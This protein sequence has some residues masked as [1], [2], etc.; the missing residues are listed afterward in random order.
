MD[1]A[2]QDVVMSNFVEYFACSGE[3]EETVGIQDREKDGQ[4]YLYWEDV[5][6]VAVHGCNYLI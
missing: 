1:W 5:P 2:P 4:Q 6:D 3:G